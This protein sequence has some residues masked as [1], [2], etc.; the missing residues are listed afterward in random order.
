[1]NNSSL[2]DCSPIDYYAQQKSAQIEQQIYYLQQTNAKLEEQINNEQQKTSELE[3]QINNEQQKT[4]E[5]EEQIDNNQQKTSELEEQINNLN[6]L[7][8][9]YLQSACINPVFSLID[10]T[11]EIVAPS[12]KQTIPFGTITYYQ[13][14]ITNSFNGDRVW[15]FTLGGDIYAPSFW[16]NYQFNPNCVVPNGFNFASLKDLVFY[17]DGSTTV[18]EPLQGTIV[19]D[20]IGLPISDAPLIVSLDW[21]P[22]TGLLIFKF[23]ITRNTLA[24]YDN[25]DAQ[26]ALIDATRFG[27][28]TPKSLFIN[29]TIRDDCRTGTFCA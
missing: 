27:Q 11:T 19:V 18:Y 8:N 1:M 13:T 29:L 14:V 9:T 4:S 28:Q 24:R 26:A 20:N 17:I 10:Y 21:N 25:F 2:N 6:N 16:I 3:E 7:V 5:L 23:S 15:T 12:D 22:D